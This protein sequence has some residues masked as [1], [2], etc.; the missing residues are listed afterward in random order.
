MQKRRDFT[1]NSIYCD[2]HGNIIDPLNGIKDLREKKVKFIGKAEDRIKEDYLRILRF[3]RFSLSIS[4]KFDKNGFIACKNL[5]N[6]ILKL[7][8]ER[9][10][11][12][13]GKIL[14]LKNIEK[15]NIF[16]KLK[17]FVELAI[18]SKIDI[19]NFEKLCS[20]ENKIKKVS[21]TRRLKFLIR[22]TNKNQNFL[23][24]LSKNSRNRIKYKFNFK[25][26]NKY[27]IV[28][29]ILEKSEDQI[30]DNLIINYA[31]G[32]INSQKFGLLKKK[33]MI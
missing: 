32:L 30:Y 2:L 9:R 23:L 12:E 21:K 6:N 4:N 26:N 18:N 27:Q 29:E 22:N 31:D 19:S 7:S 10:I 17:S 28:K 16:S 11:S 20:I 24:K 8:F 3:I 25:K 14:V 1:I 33:L 13:L 5:K 15:K